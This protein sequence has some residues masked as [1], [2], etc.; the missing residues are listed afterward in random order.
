[1]NT[2]KHNF[3][4]KQL[5]QAAGFSKQAHLAYLK[6]KSYSENLYNL[7]LNTV[8]KVRSFHPMM[9]LK[10]IF[11]LVKPDVIGRDKFIVI[12]GELGLS[13]PR[14]KNY[15]RTTFSNPS[16][17]YPNLT[18]NL[19]IR[20]INQV[21]VSDI[22]YF[23]VNN[24][25]YYI[26]FV[27]DVYS[28]RIIGFSASASLQAQSSCKALNNA[29]KCRANTCISNLIH[30]SD[31]GVQYTSN[32][33]INILKKYKISVSMCKSVYEN[34][35]IERVNG[36][37]KNEYLCCSPIRNLESLNKALKEAVYLYNFERPHWSLACMAPVEFEKS[38]SSKLLSERE[39]LVIFT[40][41]TEKILRNY[42]QGTLNL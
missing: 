39:P 12:G 31:R 7:V 14:P 4:L 11:H 21:W 9:G 10:K 30:H 19:E 2:L 26:T 20:D 33:Y 35:H 3:T 29:I 22:T 8:L 42:Y 5:C 23:S 27:E 17:F 13:L 34:T 37:I 15:Q 36:I 18:T 32:A 41:M 40:D 1:M 25:F 6:R 28:R 38:L 24:I 16:I